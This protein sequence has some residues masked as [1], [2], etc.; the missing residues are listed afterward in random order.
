MLRHSSHLLQLRV[1]VDDSALEDC[2]H[3]IQVRCHPCSARLHQRGEKRQKLQP[4]FFRR[5][6]DLLRSQSAHEHGQQQ[7]QDARHLL[8]QG[9]RQPAGI[10]KIIITSLHATNVNMKYISNPH[11]ITMLMASSRHFS[12]GSENSLRSGLR[13]KSSSPS[14]TSG[15]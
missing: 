13:R 2:N 3:I 7:R 9:N 4:Q 6:C 8:L 10:K 11:S 1:R 15:G 14:R 5:L 12:T